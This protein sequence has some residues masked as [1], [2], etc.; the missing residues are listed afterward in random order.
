MDLP[1]L[2]ILYFR[3]LI[4]GSAFE[5]TFLATILLKSPVFPYQ[6]VSKS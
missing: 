6:Y 4:T 5:V 3:D 2:Y 1:S